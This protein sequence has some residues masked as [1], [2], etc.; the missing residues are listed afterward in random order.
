MICFRCQK[1]YEKKSYYQK[2]IEKANCIKLIGETEN[3]TKKNDIIKK[4]TNVDT[5]LE[6]IIDKIFKENNNDEINELKNIVE[7]LKNEIIKLQKK[8]KILEENYSENNYMQEQ[9]KNIIEEPSMKIVKKERMNIDDEII[10]IHLCDKTLESDCSLL[11]KYY[12]EGENKDMYPIKK[13]KKNNCFYWNG[14]DWIEDDNGINLKN[15]FSSN[16]KKT[17]S[18]VNVMQGSNDNVY[19]D[20]QEYITK[21]GNKKYQNYLYNYF[22]E[23]YL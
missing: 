6:V 8:V 22:M 11:Y 10:N 9:E 23:T 12:L 13:D 2:H 4:E 15:I 16:L 18:K 21:L 7:N 14:I 3:L 1:F 20:N 17:Y 5:K 19:L